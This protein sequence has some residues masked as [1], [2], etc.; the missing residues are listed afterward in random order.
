MPLQIDHY[1][2]RIGY[3]GPRD[4]SLHTLRG[5]HR[6][7]T[8]SIAFENI[9][10]YLQR[11]V[12]QD[13][14]RI[15]EKIVIRRR[16]GWCYEQNGLLGWALKTLGFDVVRLC[17]GVRRST[18]GD[19]VMGDHLTLQVNMDEPWIA[20]VGLGGGFADP[21][22][23][24]E[25]TFLQGPWSYRL[26]RLN[27]GEWR[28]HNREGAIPPDFDFTNAPADEE[29][30]SSVGLQ[31]QTNSGSKLRKNLICMLATETAQKV[32]IGRVVSGLDSSLDRKLIDSEDELVDVLTQEFNII[33]PDI[34]GLWQS[35]VAQHEAVF[36]DTPPDQI[37]LGP[38]PTRQKT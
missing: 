30:L 9:D 19:E 32:L 33:L 23:L 14:V 26:E 22:I 6:A 29:K 13:I 38:V 20:D 35:V 7:H 16:G 28:F 10:V 27:E 15:F 36:G 24:C 1:F 11:P 34:N 21:F 4:L 8:H 31:L 12:D 5:I 37:Q 18:L 3:T 25:G 17:G 2:D